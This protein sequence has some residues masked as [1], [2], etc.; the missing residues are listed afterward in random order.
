MRLDSEREEQM[1]L[2]YLNEMKS[3]KN[4]HCSDVS[5]NQSASQSSFVGRDVRGRALDQIKDPEICVHGL[6]G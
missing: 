6:Y 5:I 4:R 2:V 1:D 3:T